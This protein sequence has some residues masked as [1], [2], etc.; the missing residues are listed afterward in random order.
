MEPA[1]HL[2]PIHPLEKFGS[3]PLSIFRVIVAHG[4]YRSWVTDVWPVGGSIYQK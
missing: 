4:N 2:T 3:D 1:R